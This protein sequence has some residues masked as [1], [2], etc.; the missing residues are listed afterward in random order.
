MNED[1]KVEVS[2]KRERPGQ[3]KELGMGTG[4]SRERLIPGSHIFGH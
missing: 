2:M 4:L 1:E 3:R